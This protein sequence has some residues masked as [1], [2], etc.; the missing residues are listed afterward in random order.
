MSIRPTL[1]YSRIISN[2]F[3]Q[4]IIRLQE[5]L[6]LLRSQI[7]QVPTIES[8]RGKNH[9]I[10]LPPSKPSPENDLI[11]ALDDR[12]ERLLQVRH[13]LDEDNEMARLLD[14]VIKQRVHIS[15]RR[16]T[17]INMALNT[18]FLIAGWGLSAF[19]TP[20]TLGKWGGQ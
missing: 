11:D 1:P 16:Q 14:S 9:Q 18:I 4:E 12:I 6:R 7:S 17:I 5:Q 3:G 15:E 2:A 8:F 13:W 19:F 10:Q 20:S